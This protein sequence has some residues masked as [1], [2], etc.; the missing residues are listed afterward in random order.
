MIHHITPNEDEQWAPAADLM[1]ALMLV[2]MFISI[3]FI[4]ILVQQEEVFKNSAEECDE[5][6]REL[7]AD[8]SSE[9]FG[10]VF[11]VEDDLTIRLNDPRIEYE[12]GDFDVP[13]EFKKFLDEFLPR[14]VRFLYERK[15]ER[16]IQEIRIEGHTSKKW[17]GDGTLSE[18]QAYI[19]NMGLSQD[20]ARKILEYYIL[21]MPEIFPSHNAHKEWAEEIITANGLSSSK[22]IRFSDGRE[23]ENASR[24]VEFRAIVSVCQKA[25][26][27]QRDRKETP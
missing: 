26:R 9:K 23:N 24:R 13:S 17:E 27:Y 1:A 6:F 7:K 19:K 18:G 11:E 2:F 8:F 14:Y 22:P 5:I 12:T 10:V 15:E 3:L 25:G 16:D 20:R 4:M 21:E